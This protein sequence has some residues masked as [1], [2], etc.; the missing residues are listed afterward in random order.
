[1]N[2]RVTINRLWGSQ[3]RDL[4]LALHVQ[5]PGVSKS[6]SHSPPG[7]ISPRQE[8]LL[9][10]QRMENVE[11][12]S[13]SSSPLWPPAFVAWRPG[14]SDPPLG[15]VPCIEVWEQGS[16]TSRQQVMTWSTGGGPGGCNASPGQSCAPCIVPRGPCPVFARRAGS[17]PLTLTDCKRQLVLCSEWGHHAT[18]P[19]GRT[20]PGPSGLLVGILGESVSSWLV[21]TLKMGNCSPGCVGPEQKGLLRR[22][23]PPPRKAP[24]PGPEQNVTA[25]GPRFSRFPL[26]GWPCHSSGLVLGQPGPAPWL[27]GISGALRCYSGPLGRTQYLKCLFLQGRR[28]P[29][30]TLALATESRPLLGGGGACASAL[31][32][33]PPQLCMSHRPWLEGAGGKG[34]QLFTGHAGTLPRDGTRGQDWEVGGV[35][36]W[37]GG[38]GRDAL[39]LRANWRCSGTPRRPEAGKTSF[40]SDLGAYQGPLS[41]PDWP[42][43]RVN[44]PQVYSCHCGK[45]TLT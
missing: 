5:P 8:V 25:C 40:C 7:D 17:H 2:L 24:S 35:G 43:Q 1:M 32:V 36:R 23:Q 16:Q 14:H 6:R 26:P 39:A 38:K 10:E 20:E 19:V 27:G 34:A 12:K 11:V 44:F 13:L 9:E 28:E 37:A 30:L 18:R 31:S 42:R 3:A 15:S 45:V 22:E 29:R 41:Q 33:A 21:I 4:H